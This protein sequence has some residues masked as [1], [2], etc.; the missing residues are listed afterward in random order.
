[1]KYILALGMTCNTEEEACSYLER[2]CET[3]TIYEL[4]EDA[5]T[6]GVQDTYLFLEGYVDEDPRP[7]LEAL[8]EELKTKNIEFSVVADQ[9]TNIFEANNASK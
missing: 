8:I 7:Q 4:C 5:E 1:M 3:F 6:N 9:V 2:L